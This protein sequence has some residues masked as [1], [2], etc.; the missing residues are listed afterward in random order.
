MD[1]NVG[2]KVLVT[3]DNWFIAPDGKQ[4]RSVFGRVKDICDAKQTLGIDTNRNSTNWYMQVGNMILAG[5][6]IHYAIKC[7]SVNT[8][9]K[10]WYEENGQHKERDNSMIYCAD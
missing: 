8:D 2:D 3:T 10:D 4:Y 5:C 1:V 6:Q 9:T 7:D